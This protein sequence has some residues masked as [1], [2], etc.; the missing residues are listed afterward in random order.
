M[1]DR[2]VVFVDVSV[3]LQTVQAAAVVKNKARVNRVARVLRYGIS[4]LFIEVNDI[5]LVAGPRI[6]LGTPGFSVPRSTN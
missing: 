3:K 2:L 4:S 5:E 6:E 1:T